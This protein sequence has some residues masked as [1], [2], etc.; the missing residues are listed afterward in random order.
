MSLPAM[1]LMCAD[2]HL[3]RAL[4]GTPTEPAGYQK[5]FERGIDPDVEDPEQCHAHSEIPDEW[6]AVIDILNYQ[7]RVRSRMRSIFQMEGLSQNRCLAEALW[8]G[9]EHEAMHLETFL[10]MLLQSEKTIPPPG[11]NK[12]DFRKLFHDARKSQ[13]PNEWFSIPNQTLSVGLDISSKTMPKASFGWDNEIPARTVTVPAFEAHARPITNGEFAK[14]LEANGIHEIP[15]SWALSHPDDGRSVANGVNGYGNNGTAGLMSRVAVRTVF[16]LVPLEFAQDW[17][18]MASYDELHGYAQWTNC[19]I[20]TFKE[21]RSLYSYAAQ[22]KEAKR[23]K[24][25]NGHRYVLT[26]SNLPDH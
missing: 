12:P 7:E 23:S 24:R 20:P 21:A 3:T 25:A 6:P 9:F 17:P 18:V 4:R 13:K 15:A 5:M 10:Y 8:I 2:I 14:Y 16:G 26:I 19:R 22:S 1:K 11:V